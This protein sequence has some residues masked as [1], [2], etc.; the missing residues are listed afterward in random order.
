MASSYTWNVGSGL[1]NAAANW[2]DLTTAT[3]PSLTAPG[4]ADT[5]TIA[6]PTS[7]TDS[8]VGGPGAAAILD[9]SG[10]LALYGQLNLGTLSATNGQID[11]LA[12]GVAQAS[13]A[14]L[15]SAG[16]LV[17]GVGADFAVAGTATVSGF[18]V[19]LSARDHGAI[20]L[21]ALA[22]GGAVLTVDSTATFEIGAA[23]GAAAGLLTVDAGAALSGASALNGAVRDDGLITASSALAIAGA[24]AG[25]GTIAIA[26]FATASFAGAVAAGPTLAFQDA[27]GTLALGT[28]PF[29]AGIAGLVAG[30]V[31]TLA[32][33]G[34]TAAQYTAT[35]TNTGTLAL[36]GGGVT[37]ETLTL[38][39]NYAGRVFLT[40]P[41]SGGAE[42]VLAPNG[43]AAVAAA[44]AGTTAADS[45]LWTSSASG[46]AWAATANWTDTTTATA[47][48]PLAPGAANNVTVAGGTGGLLPVITGDGAAASLTLTASSALAG[49]FS[50]GALVQAAAGSLDLLAGAA[51]TAAS[52]TA[53]GA[54]FV[55]HAALTVSG[56]LDLASSGAVWGFDHAT[57]Q[58]GT[59]S[60]AGASGIAVSLDAS[61]T[62]SV[63]GVG[64]ASAGALNI[65]AGAL[66]AGSGTIE[67]AIVNAGTLRTDAGTSGFAAPLVLAAAVSGSGG[68]LAIAAGDTLALHNAVSSG[69]SIEFAGAA[70]TLDLGQAGAIAA[71]IGGFTLGNAIMVP[72]AVAAIA[73][74]AATGS[75]VE[76]DASGAALATLDLAGIAAGDTP[77]LVPGN[78]GGAI[79]L[80]AGTPTAG[81]AVAVSGSTGDAYTWTA[82]GGDWSTTANWT[83]TS[84]ATT[85][86]PGS[87]DLVIIPDPVA[88]P[89]AWQIIRGAGNAARLTVQGEIALSGSFNV[90]GTLTVQG[91]TATT[92]TL[93]LLGGASL[94]AGSAVIGG[95]LA[96]AGPGA[97]FAAAGT[98]TLGSAGAAA[99]LAAIDQGR[100]T[101]GGLALTGLA[102]SIAVDAASVI[103]IGTAQTGAAGVLTVDAGI[104]IGGAGV[105]ITGAVANNGTVATLSGGSS[106]IHGDVSGSG[107]LLVANASQLFLTGTVAASQT[108][109]LSGT[110]NGISDSGGAIL[111]SV[112]GFAA[113][114]QIN[115]AG[116]MTRASFSGTAS[117]GTLALADSSGATLATLNLSGDYRTDT[118][119]TSAANGQ[120]A[121][122]LVAAQQIACFAG[123]TQIDTPA[124][125]VAVEALRVG[126]PVRTRWGETLPIVWIG[127]RRIHC[128]RHPRPWDIWPVRVRADAFAPGMP[129]RDLLLSPDHAV[130]FHE[131]LIPVRY[132]VNG[133]TIAQEPIDAVTYW[134]VEL[135][136]HD[137]LLA[138]GLPCESY[139]DTGNRHAFDG[140]AATW[141]H[142]R[143]GTPEDAEDV[144]LT[145]ACAPLVRGG[146]ALVRARA[147]LLGRARLLGHRLTEQ[148]DLALQAGARRIAPRRDADGLWSFDLP[149]GTRAAWLVSRNAVPMQVRAD[150]SD[151]RRLGVAVAEIRLDGR[152][153]DRCDARLAEGWHAPEADWRWTDGAACVAAGGARR[154]AVRILPLLRYWEAEDNA[155]NRPGTSSAVPR[156]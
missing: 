143:F 118:F 69:Q 137:V 130:H 10:N 87:A 45:Y 5:A 124:G 144:W 39:G 125:P 119:L 149:A 141:L 47:N 65:A 113:G 57:V 62:L 105:Q 33:P 134:H 67:A 66:V 117:G 127:S 106:T 156:P 122:T 103:E 25:T 133:A 99:G 89:G 18:G 11:I 17:N 145:Q 38:L 2:A 126:Q 19:P 68:T 116:M 30:D 77:L 29:A 59:L 152:P 41:Q 121:I 81:G 93:A 73:F 150:G 115:L 79:V 142:P 76:S 132:L 110:G 46:G 91:L 153:L 13:A 88:S 136:R 20:T 63:G 21:A 129:R 24:V 94:A 7:S 43:I 111:G 112:T 138:E 64:T 22:A 15:S 34:I 60:F 56:K 23:G 4:T 52:A 78:A 27:T 154:L 131:A 49:S 109:A 100:I 28:Q 101:L 54:V 36:T 107:T 75:L 140:G 102:A 139:L 8:L 70:G 82:L 148:P 135:E 80:A 146:A 61:S 55:D 96:A 147:H 72:G 86:A 155:P 84:A 90:G 32:T 71:P 128:A 40:T 51:L 92:G 120:T 53:H 26:S 35:G 48:P 74:D 14:G 1:W 9:V 114:D 104:D 44:P 123:G 6:G 108:L 3:T 58:A 83:D 97:R 50:T 95:S 98:L 12:G 85:T 31:I 151:H 42:L 16:L 37:L